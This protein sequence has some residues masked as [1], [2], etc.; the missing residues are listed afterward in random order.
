MGLATLSDI[1]NKFKQLDATI[2]Y[3]SP[4]TDVVLCL[5]SNTPSLETINIV[6][7]DCVEDFQKICSAGIALS[8][9]VQHNVKLNVT[10]KFSA[11]KE[12]PVGV[13]DNL[14][15]DVRSSD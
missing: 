13:P 6:G 10:V 11:S 8:A 7:I 9:T 12:L 5:I 3:K 14:T 15:I 4:G 1:K 2:H